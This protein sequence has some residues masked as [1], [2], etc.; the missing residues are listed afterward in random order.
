MH[1]AGP[2]VAGFD[3]RRP[4]ETAAQEEDGDGRSNISSQ[5]LAE[6]RSGSEAMAAITQRASPASSSAQVRRRARRAEASTGSVMPTCTTTRV[7]AGVGDDEVD[8]EVD[9]QHQ[10]QGGMVPLEAGVGPLAIYGPVGLHAAVRQLGVFG[11]DHAL[12]RAPDAVD[13]A[14]FHPSIPMPSPPP[15]FR[16]IA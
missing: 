5:R 2:D 13:H 3:A 6:N 4:N 12:A 14:Q 11:H 15:R 7:L 16:L 10:V 8:D 9:E 1:A